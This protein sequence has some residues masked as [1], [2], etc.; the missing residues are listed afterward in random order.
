MFAWGGTWPAQ[1]LIRC[2]GR[3]K[4]SPSLTPHSRDYKEHLGVGGEAWDGTPAL[5]DF[6]LDFLSVACGP[7]HLGWVC[8]TESSMCWEVLT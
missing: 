4:P 1:G 7:V 2:S 3:S 5:D 6:C 8:M